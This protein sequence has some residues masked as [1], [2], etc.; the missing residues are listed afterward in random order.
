MSY[1]PLN[2]AELISYKRPQA[3]RKTGRNGRGSILERHQQ[4]HKES[5]DC[6]GDSDDGAD[7]SDEGSDVSYDE[8]SGSEET[9]CESDGDVEP[10]RDSLQDEAEDNKE[11]PHQEKEWFEPHGLQKNF[12]FADDSSLSAHAESR[13]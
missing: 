10:D 6:T 3:K 9:A 2:D 1:D 7:S 8:P 13:V 11:T 4:L 12:T 5:D